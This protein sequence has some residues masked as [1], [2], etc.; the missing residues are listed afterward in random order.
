[1]NDTKT[2]TILAEDGDV[3]I[4]ELDGCPNPVAVLNDRAM[5]ELVLRLRA[6]SS[7]R[8]G[9]LGPIADLLGTIA[10]IA[11]T[12][13][14]TRNKY[15]GGPSESVEAANL[16]REVERTLAEAKRLFGGNDA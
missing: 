11:H 15:R 6:A 4:G 10:R 5:S 12:Y 16:I 2:F 7:A 13:A 8:D 3:L 14:V 9:D 1:M